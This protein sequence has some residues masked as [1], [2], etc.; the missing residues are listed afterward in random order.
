VSSARFK[1]DPLTIGLAVVAVICLAVGAAIVS[2]HP[3]RGALAL[4]VG[5]VLA[6]G[7]VYAAMRAGKAAPGHQPSAE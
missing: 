4:V 2:G 7:A 6:G 5:V 1:I 3:K